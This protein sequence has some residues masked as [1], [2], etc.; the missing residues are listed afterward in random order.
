MFQITV[1]TGTIVEEIHF[2]EDEE[3]I[4]N[5]IGKQHFIST[6]KSLNN[7]KGFIEF[8]KKTG[9]FGLGF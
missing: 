2:L 9:N 8:K 3:L 7:L 1:W 6:P 4:Y 5:A